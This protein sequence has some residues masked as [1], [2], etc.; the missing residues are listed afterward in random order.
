MAENAEGRN[1]ADAAGEAP[2]PANVEERLPPVEPLLSVLVR[3]MPSGILVEGEERR[4]LYANDAFCKMF[5]ETLTRE[6]LFGSGCDE[7][8]SNA[9]SLF[10]D[11]EGFVRRTE[12]TL[13]RRRPVSGEEF[14]LADGRVFERD[15]VPVFVGEDYRGHLWHYRDVSE[16]RQQERALAESE[17]HFRSLV[18]H[19]SDIIAVVEANGTIR[20]VSP[21]VGRLLGYEPEE[22]VGT[23]I[24]SYLRPEE[25][26]QI[27]ETFA[28]RLSV[29]G[30]HEP[31][32]FSARRKSG[33][34][35]RLEVVSNNLLH[36]ESVGA[37]VMNARD[38]TRKREAEEALKESE[39]RSRQL[40]EQSV[41]ALF[42]HDEAGRLADCNARAERLYG[43]CARGVAFHDG[44]GPLMRRAQYRGEGPEGAG[45]RHPLAAGHEG[46]AG[47]LRQRPR[48]RSQAQGR[49][50]RAGR[51]ACRPDRLRWEAHDTVRRP[52]HHRTQAG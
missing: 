8:L 12:E 37:L 19:G 11:P 44:G 35:A 40:F 17:E 3:S 18:G 21:S 30:V 36:D 5:S 43:L 31:V 47:H 39:S 52:R 29:P 48:G 20:Y 14:A 24:F 4:I 42:V 46:G 2:S 38:V 13:E 26:R 25:T 15:Y 49:H 51:D 6:E 9:A 45:R 1:E 33:S 50:H 41:D 23:G 27:S 34:W 22:M 28:E 10:S 32:E 16:R 7:A